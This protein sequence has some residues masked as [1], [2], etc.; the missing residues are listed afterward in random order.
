MMLKMTRLGVLGELLHAECGYLHD[1]RELKYRNSGEGLWRIAHS[2]KRN[3]DLYPTHGLGP[4]AQCMSINRGNQFAHI[5]SMSCQSR[6]LNLY[7]AEKSG[8]DSPQAKQKYALGD[9]VTSMIKTVKGQ[10][11]VVTHDTNTPRPYSRI[12][13]LQ[14]TKGIFRNWPE[15]KIYIEGRSPEPHTWESVDKY[16]EQYEHPLWKSQAAKGEGIGHGSMDYLES[17]RLIEA[18]R[19]GTYP[20]MDVYDAAAWSSVVELSER[21]IAHKSRTVD[22]PDFTRG[23]WKEREPLGI[24]G[25]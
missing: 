21:S 25:A 2:I 12:D 24:V 14:G 9:V 13:M 19:T 17:Y 15:P 22:F 16:Y 18:L 5:V 3:A 7:A 23:A 11:I 8:P 1:L 6:G 10:T 20:D 4:A